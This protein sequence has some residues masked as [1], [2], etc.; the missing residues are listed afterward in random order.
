LAMPSHSRVPERESD[1]ELERRAAKSLWRGLRQNTVGLI[2]RGVVVL[3]SWA[4]G[5]SR[6]A[7]PTPSAP[8]AWGSMY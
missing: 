8:T 5:C 7:T 6:R 3:S 1:A 4:S 2:G